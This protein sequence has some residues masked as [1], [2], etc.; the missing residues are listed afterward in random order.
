M[1]TRPKRSAWG[2]CK[3]CRVPAHERGVGRCEGGFEGFGEGGG[4]E[5]LVEGD[6]GFS[7]GGRGGGRSW[8]SIGFGVGW[9]LGL[10]N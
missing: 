2:N 10:I 5:G 9:G 1:P 8:M 3:P 4:G 7:C 6:E